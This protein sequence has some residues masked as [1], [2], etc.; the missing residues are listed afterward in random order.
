[1]LRPLCPPLH[2]SRQGFSPT[3]R[4][5]R[6]AMWWLASIL[7]FLILT[8]RVF[9]EGYQYKCLFKAQD[10]CTLPS[11]N[12]NV[13][14]SKIALGPLF[15]PQ[16]SVVV[17]AASSIKGLNSWLLAVKIKTQQMHATIA[18]SCLF[19]HL[20]SLKE[21]GSFWPSLISFKLSACWLWRLVS[22]T[23]RKMKEKKFS[24]RSNLLNNADFYLFLFQSPPW[25]PAARKA[26]TLIRVIYSCL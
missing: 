1:M 15:H 24:T 17:W 20:F 26:P 10:Y 8:T 22:P 13:A 21:T 4:V 9:E 16:L 19:Y 25:Q 23:E 11:K 12:V 18:T 7:S 3:S 5:Q 14:Q 2:C 6:T